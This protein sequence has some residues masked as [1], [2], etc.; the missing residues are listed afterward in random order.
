MVGMVYLELNGNK[1]VSRE[2]V[3]HLFRHRCVLCQHPA[4]TVHEIIPK[5]QTSDWAVLENRVALCLGC[6]M[7]VHQHGAKIWVDELR[8][9]RTLQLER[10]GYK[11]TEG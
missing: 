11:L 4:Y 6:H 9:K 2:V 3:L 1:P 10:Y 8:K 5:S 7:K